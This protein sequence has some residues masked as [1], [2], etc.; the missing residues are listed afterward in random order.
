MVIREAYR[1]QETM[2]SDIHPEK[3]LGLLV[4]LTRGT[5][6]VFNHYPKFV[7]DYRARERE[8]IRK[9]E[10]EY[11]R[12]RWRGSNTHTHTHRVQNT[13]LYDVSANMCQL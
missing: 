1:M 2:P 3:L 13:G 11:L 9:E 7:V 6:P 10:E 12:E 5:Y 8:K 4:P